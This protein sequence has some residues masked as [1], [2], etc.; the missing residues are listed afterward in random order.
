MSITSITVARDQQWMES[1]D[2]VVDPVG[3]TVNMLPDLE[4]LSAVERARSVCSPCLVKAECFEWALANRVTD[5]V[6]GGFTVEEIGT[7]RRRRRRREL[8]AEKTSAAQATAA[9]SA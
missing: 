6:W 1:G 9:V 4:A 5:G 2:C 8:D 7:V 3:R